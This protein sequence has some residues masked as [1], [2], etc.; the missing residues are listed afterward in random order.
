M[1]A[2]THSFIHSSP[3]LEAACKSMYKR[4]DE[5]N[6][7]HLYD[8]VLLSNKKG[9]PWICVTTWVDPQNIMSSE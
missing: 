2:K 5:Q 3:R 8:G 4:K 9:R 7:T 1:P 6:V